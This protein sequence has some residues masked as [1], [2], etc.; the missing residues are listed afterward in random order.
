MDTT[1]R[2]VNV[3]TSGHSLQEPLVLDI[4]IDRDFVKG[5]IEDLLTMSNKEEEPWEEET[6]GATWIPIDNHSK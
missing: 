6:F 3:V 4:A 2:E 1:I 5:G